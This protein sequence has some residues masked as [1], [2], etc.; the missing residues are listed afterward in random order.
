MAV[1]FRKGIKDRVLNMMIDELK[2]YGKM[3]MEEAYNTRDFTN[4]TH[5]L[6]DSYGSAVYY[7]GQMVNGTLQT[8]GAPEATESKDW[9]G[10]KLRGR[11]VVTNYLKNEYKPQKKGL[12]LAVVAAMPYRD[13]LEIKY[14]Y[15][16]ITGANWMMR[17]LANTFSAK[18]GVR[19]HGITISNIQV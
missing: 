12:S 7:N 6:K 2:M 11:K 3:V 15:R 17:S 14:K 8:L 4:R 16:V 1:V 18:F 19:K 5:N 9:Y 10:K 13:V